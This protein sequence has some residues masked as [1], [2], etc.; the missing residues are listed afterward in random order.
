[1][2]VKAIRAAMVVVPGAA[3][4][5]FGVSTPAFA[6]EVVCY[7][8]G[9]TVQVGDPGDPGGGGGTQPTGGGQ[10]RCADHT[11][12]TWSCYTPIFGWWSDRDECYY[13]LAV[14]QPPASDPA[15]HGHRP[16]EGAVYEATCPNTP[17][18]GGGAVWMRNPPPGSGGTL[19]PAATLAERALSRLP[20]PAARV[21]TAPSE[22]TY[23]NFAT[24]LWIPAAQWRSLSATAAIGGRSVTLT[25]TPIG[26]SWDMGEGDLR[27]A[28]PGTPWDPAGPDGQT[29]SCSYSYR[30]SSTGQPGSGNDRGYVV[31]ATVT[32]LL[33]WQCAGS[34]DQAAGDL[35]ARGVPAQPAR[36]RVLERQSVVVG[37]D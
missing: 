26:V 21:A 27:C 17:G 10:R 6:D 20:F 5:V 32:Y 14:P 11:G 37:A 13:R 3:A 18:T 7:P 15:W 12:Q 33:H 2:L 16:G 29:S 9:C 28:G 34:C 36:L 23:V 4:V 24:F 1:M 8:W 35:P 22:H 31:R 25:A 30:A 19:P